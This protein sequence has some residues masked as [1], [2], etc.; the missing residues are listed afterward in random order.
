[1]LDVKPQEYFSSFGFSDQHMGGMAFE[2]DSSI[3]GWL[4]GEH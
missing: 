2:H 3:M 1:V 4:F